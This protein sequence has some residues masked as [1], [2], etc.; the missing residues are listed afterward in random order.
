MSHRVLGNGVASGGAS[1]AVTSPDF[2]Q[3]WAIATVGN[4][5][6]EF[7]PYFVGFGYSWQLFKVAGN[8]NYDVSQAQVQKVVDPSTNSWVNV[9]NQTPNVAPH[10]FGAPGY[11]EPYDSFVV[12]GDASVFLITTSYGFEGV[13]STGPQILRSADGGSTWSL[14]AVDTVEV[15][16][17]SQAAHF[18]LA[19]SNPN[20]VYM[21]ANVSYT[22]GLGHSVA[23]FYIWRSDDL[24]ATWA[25]IGNGAVDTFVGNADPDAFFIPT[26]AE[27]TTGTPFYALRD[28]DEAGGAVRGLYNGSVVSGT[29]EPVVFDPT[30][31][32]A[33]IPFSY[34]PNGHILAAFQDGSLRKST[35]DGATWS[36]VNPSLT[37][38]TPTGYFTFL[39]G[40]GDGAFIGSHGDSSNPIG[41][42]VYRSMDEGATWTKVY[43]G[44]IFTGTAGLFVDPVAL[45]ASSAA[46]ATLTPHHSTTHLKTLT[47]TP[48]ASSAHVI[49]RVFKY[50]NT[51]SVA[52]P[53]LMVGACYLN[54]RTPRPAGSL[55]VRAPFVAAQSNNIQ[56]DYP[57]G[58]VQTDSAL[59]LLD[60]NEFPTLLQTGVVH[61]IP[62][63]EQA[64]AMAAGGTM[65]KTRLWFFTQHL[66]TVDY[67]V[68]DQQYLDMLRSFY[69]ERQ[70]DLNP[71]LFQDWTDPNPRG[72]YIGT[73]D[74]VS[75]LFKIRGDSF[76]QIRDIWRVTRTP[77]QVKGARDTYSRTPVMLTEYDWDVTTGFLTFHSA[78]PAGQDLFADV[79]N[80]K[81]L[82]FFQGFTTKHV[83]SGGWLPFSVTYKG[84]VAYSAQMSMIQ[85]KTVV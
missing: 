68:V 1:V 54:A 64:S 52:F 62:R 17:D 84:G 59:P 28:S 66:V 55:Q 29:S 42:S 43:D 50:L 53:S 8:S 76:G 34:L 63:K 33:P 61:V 57:P 13:S 15:G 79:C 60:Y 46:M 67:E 74:G 20:R 44:L 23:G 9:G 25:R 40:L 47:A 78:P 69:D 77:S 51:F 2:G 75:T 11:T 14:V 3:T 48:S 30:P 22:N 4:T 19:P 82:V 12:M 45:S 83:H 27:N 32:S 56:L 7:V 6:F 37:G 41:S 80:E 36:T 85:Q 26:G 70:G 49:K 10:N 31:A 16:Q 39:L 71:F 21:V 38:G 5:P 73:G 81:Y 65:Y 18:F 58:A 35:D 24:G 72:E